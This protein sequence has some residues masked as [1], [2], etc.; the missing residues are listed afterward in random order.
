MNTGIVP[1]TA[2]V[3]IPQAVTEQPAPTEN[4]TVTGNV[5]VE[6]ITPQEEVVTGYFD[7]AYD[8]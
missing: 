5:P 6:V 8:K 4:I 7:T 3:E 1:E 2:I